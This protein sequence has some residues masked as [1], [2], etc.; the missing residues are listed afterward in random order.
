MNVVG[1]EDLIATEEEE[2]IA[3]AARLANDLNR[4]AQL[5]GGMRDRLR[6]SRLIDPKGF[7]RTLEDA[8]RQMWRTWCT[9]T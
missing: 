3:K 4:L 2:Y 9:S 8:Y 6:G 7:T 1:L 5:R